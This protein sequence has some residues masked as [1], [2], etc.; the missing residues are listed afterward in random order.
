MSH[1]SGSRREVLLAGAAGVAAGVFG[2]TGMA[3]EEATVAAT[4]ATCPAAAGFSA[5]P[6]V[7]LCAYS[8]RKL[9][10]TPG[11]PGKMS[12]FDIIDLCA[13]WNV[14]GVELTSYYFLKE[15]DEY[16]N[17]LKRHAFHRGVQIIGTPVGNNACEPPGPKADA[18]IAKI[19]HWV[20]NAVKLGAPTIRVF[21]GRPAK[22]VERE[23]SF[24]HAVAAL[25]KC[26]DYAGARGVMLVLEVH[27]YLTETADDITKIVDAIGHEWLGINMD[28]GNFLDDPYGAI[29]RVAPRA[30]TCHLKTTVHQE[31]GSKVLVPADYGRIMSIMRKAGYRGFLSLEYEGADAEKDVPVHIRKIQEAISAT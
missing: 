6:K 11:K 13:R 25:R 26:A 22:G 17:K 28:C 27:G 24:Q 31:A 4:L 2:K 23:Q 18:E 19:C 9:M 7:G 15:D 14:D 30:F 10:D 1:W 8:Y 29:E 21:A 5:R 16:L 3:A 12:L 20:D